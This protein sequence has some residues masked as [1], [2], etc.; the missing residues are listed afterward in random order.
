MT[1]W[2]RI[3]SF[4]IGIVMM[5]GGVV[6]AL[7]GSE[8]VPLIVFI[9]ALSL[10]ISGLKMLIYYFSLARHMVDG[11]QILI[12]GLILFDLGAFTCTLTSYSTIYVMGYLIAV[13]AFSGFVD[14]TRALEAKRLSAPSWKMNFAT[15][16]VNI[17]LA[18][19]CIVFLRSESIAVYIYS[20]G[21][22]WSA[23]AQIIT[24]FRKT[25]VVYI[26]PS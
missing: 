21:L 26:T 13:H 25:A 24:A 17:I 6:L 7:A 22:I 20:A 4:I 9:L 3:E 2:Q 5:L 15:G 8:S 1:K 10:T 18:V 11:D 23:I 19:M 14:V 16:A 12:R